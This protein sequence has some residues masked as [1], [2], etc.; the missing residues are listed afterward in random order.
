MPF[1]AVVVV[2][3]GVVA[4]D[5]GLESLDDVREAGDEA[6]RLHLPVDQVLVVNLPRQTFDLMRIWDGRK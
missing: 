2:E 3:A 6:A 4:D 1:V 5:D